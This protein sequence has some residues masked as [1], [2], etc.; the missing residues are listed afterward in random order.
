M[1]VAL[2][3]IMLPGMPP[4]VI[5]VRVLGVREPLS[6]ALAAANADCS[7]VASEVVE[8]VSDVLLVAVLEASRA[9]W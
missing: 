7:A 8:I 6:D 5:T 1:V 2:L 3:V 4:G 9:P